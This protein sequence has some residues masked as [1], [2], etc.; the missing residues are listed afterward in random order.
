MFVFSLDPD[1]KSV[2]FP[3]RFSRTGG[4]EGRQTRV[5]SCPL[6]DE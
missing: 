5:P 1:I 2:V 3:P 4:L 6:I